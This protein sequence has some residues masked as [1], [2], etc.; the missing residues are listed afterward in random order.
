VKTRQ[1]AGFP[2]M[3]IDAY[4]LMCIKSSEIAKETAPWR[5]AT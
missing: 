3:H 4:A 2:H 1:P 5:S